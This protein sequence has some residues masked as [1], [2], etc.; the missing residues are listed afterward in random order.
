MRTERAGAS[1][2]T[3]K[4]NAVDEAT[5]SGPDGAVAIVVGYT[6]TPI[7]EAVLHAAIEEARRRGAVLHVVNASRGD[8]YVDNNMADA[9]QL[10]DLESALAASGV[11]HQVAQQVGRGEPAEELLDMAE[12]TSAELVVIGLRRRTPVGKLL[13]G[14]TAQRVLLDAPCSVLAVKVR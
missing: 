1:P 6:P 3:D 4:E 14:S 10:S 12:K 13:M 2:G 7:G 9:E 5:K 11:P 8:A